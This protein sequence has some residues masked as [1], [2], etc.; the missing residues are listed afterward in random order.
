MRSI[1]FIWCFLPDKVSPIIALVNRRYIY[2][3]F[4][5][6][7]YRNMVSNKYE[8]LKY[9]CDC[10]YDILVFNLKVIKWNAL[11]L[12]NSFKTYLLFDTEYVKITARYNSIF[13]KNCLECDGG[14]YGQG[15][16]STCGSCINNTQ[17]HHITGTCVQGCGP[18]YQG[19]KCKEG[20]SNAYMLDN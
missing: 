12:D 8:S 17:C 2:N 16:S 11:F 10:K 19:N 4:D 13:K 9:Q 20:I 1:Y 7:A 15:C 18:G 3:H 14:T 6:C 5:I